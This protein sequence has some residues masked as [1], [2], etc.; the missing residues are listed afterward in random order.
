MSSPAQYDLN[1]LAAIKPVMD[2][3]LAQISMDVE[4]FLAASNVQSGQLQ[5]A[6]DELHRLTGVLQMAHLDGVAVV[7]STLHRALT[8]VLDHP[9]DIS[10]LHRDVYRQALFG[11]THF[12]DTLAAGADNS[13]VRLFAQYQALQQLRGME[14]AFEQDLFFPNLSVMLPIEVLTDAQMEMEPGRIKSLRS[15][16]QQGLMRWLREEDRHAALLQMQLA[17]Q[18]V[19]QSVPQSQTRAFWWVAQGVLD[20]LRHDGLSPELSPR[21]LLG[22]IDQQ[23]R[24]LVTPQQVAD[25]QPAAEIQRAVLI[26]MLYLVSRSHSVGERVEAIKQTY[27]LDS[28]LPGLSLLPV[29]E[30]TQLLEAMRQ[31]LRASSE[32]WERC[33]Q[34]EDAACGLFIKSSEQI[35]QQSEK[36]DRNTLQYLAGQIYTLSQHAENSEYAAPLAIDMAMALLLLESG[37]DHYS[38]L[39]SG[40]Q[41][42]ARIL[43]ERMTS[44]DRKLPEDVQQLHKLIDLHGHMEQDDMV[45]SLSRE[46]LA[47]LQHIE[48][49]LN[50]FFSDASK[51]DELSGLM[52]LIDQMLG[53][54]R[55]LSLDVAVR[56]LMQLR[57]AVLPY[58]HDNALPQRQQSYVI[59][60]AVSA[61]ENY[62]QQ[63]GHGKAPQTDAL[64]NSLDELERLQLPGA[65]AMLLASD[66]T[67]NAKVQHPIGDDQELLEI[68]LEEAHEV[69]GIMRSHLDLC[70]LH[71]ESRELLNTIRRG[72]HTL[73]GS[74]RMVGLT[75]LGEVAWCVERALNRWSNDQRPASAPLLDFVQ[76]AVTC[77]DVWVS[78]LERHGGVCIQAEDLIE[79]ARLIEEGGMPQI[80]VAAPLV[81]SPVE[82]ENVVIGDVSLSAVLFRIS[83]AEASQNAAVLRQQYVVFS[84]TVPPSV[85]YDFM[86]AAH[87]LAGVNRTIGFTDIAE[88]A[89]A[90][91]A[92]L[93]ARI[94]KVFGLTVAQRD[95]IEQVVAELE[96][97][98]R[99]ICQRQAPLP[100]ADLVVLLNSG[101]ELLI[102]S[103]L[104]EELLASQA[105]TAVSAEE[106]ALAV[107]ETVA[108]GGVQVRGEDAQRSQV[109]DDLDEQLL[110]VFLEEADE[111]CPNIGSSL[112]A[113]RTAPQEGAHLQVLRRLLH[114]LKGSSRMAGAMRIGETAHEMEGYLAAAQGSVVDEVLLGRLETALDD[115]NAKLLQLRPEFKEVVQPAPVAAASQADWQQDRRVPGVERVVQGS[116]LRVRAE[117]VDRLVNEAGEISVAR[118][119]IQTEMRAFKEGL[120]ELTG[121]V[122]RLRRQLREVE[123]Q[124]ESQMQARISLSHDSAELFDPLE[125]DR[126]TRLQEL[127]RFMNESVHDVQTVQQ[128][129]L[130]NIDKTEA[131]VSA[132]ARINRELQQGLMSV[133]MVPFSNLSERLYRIVR[134]TAKELGKRANLE[135]S[136]TTVDLDRSVLEKMTAPFEHLLRNAIVHGLEDE[137]TRIKAGKA[138]IGEIR[139]SLRQENNEIIFEFE[140]DGMGVDLDAL[141]SKA[142]S[143]GLL[144]SGDYSS[145]EQ[146]LQLIF[147]SGL[148]TARSVNEVAGR[149]IGMD[150]VRSEIAALGGRIDVFSRPGQGMHFT[151]HLPLTLAITQVLTV[152]AGD[153]L[154][155]LPSTM[156]KQVR[157]LNS[158]DLAHLYAT[159]YLD[160]QNQRYPFHSLA[161]ML[162]EDAQVTAGQARN[163]VILL[164]SGDQYIALHVDEFL[165][166]HEAVIKN[167]GPQL[168]RLPGITG[169]TVRGDGLVVLIL[170]PLQLPQRTVTPN[171]RRVVEPQ[172]L[173]PLVMI[174]DDSL[175][176]RKI[177]SRLLQRAGYQ[178]ATA[179]D[180]VDALEQ[181]AHISPDVMLL[182]IEMPR[183]DGF[184]LTRQLRRNAAM[185]QLPIIMIT[186]R[187]ADKHRNHAMELGVNAYLGKPYQEDDLLAHI[188]RLVGR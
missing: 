2:V 153:A 188:A 59:A 20:C 18:G 93:Q 159:G 79:T 67:L 14:C 161:Q 64:Q 116:I 151:I 66:T 128:S 157:Q 112:R 86:R 73:K 85:H 145:D 57:E 109:Q 16:Y 126:F 105:V 137:A 136:G 24:A 139:L 114:T 187:S 111:L 60:G 106:A 183:M 83:S 113:W 129:L 155:A 147:V 94:G 3:S 72:F 98:T 68:F 123:I 69:L 120:L 63:L 119:R 102:E 17:L 107:T 167:I 100:R 52:R 184:E 43:S 173:Q 146:L 178:V 51:Q 88:L 40:F 95:L 48:Q 160:W 26:E 89:Y 156:I 162:G 11:I 177:T 49:A 180:G 182:D 168:S 90:L 115:I 158:F 78:E 54:L 110:P 81:A 185:Q 56:L 87:T 186:S 13:P 1:T 103:E 118:S 122:A 5:V 10:S 134:Q 132:Q 4:R 104:P 138:A 29:G 30:V 82:D 130:K 176:V 117:V 140:D 42:Q 6:L 150:V 76:Q 152:R 74:G 53:G 91:E 101:R 108:L 21:K 121:S 31:Q 33:V 70:S 154:Y 39:G 32:N 7:C 9:R 172:K 50:A 131:A 35:A 142:Q 77:F 97:M 80:K 45:A 47:N 36:L 37:I 148:S 44:A 38:N 166:N 12:L 96:L 174:V 171:S 41:E 143:K 181:L 127:T 34:G 144:Q 65:Q 124:A 165:G 28:Y 23:I 125:F 46:M 84:S 169:A 133:R 92:W 179:K 71:P 58:T 8:E 19:M 170:N 164:G 55:I 61:L 141:R 99:G 27:A 62:I 22:R 135:L 75:D 15:Q 175:T 25:V 163:A 149:G